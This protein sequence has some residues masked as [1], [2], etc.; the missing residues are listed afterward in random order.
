MRLEKNKIGWFVHDLDYENVSGAEILKLVG[1]D[2]LL[3]VK[4]KKPVEPELL[5]KLYRKLGHV[6]MQNEKVGSALPGYPFICRVNQ[7]TGMFHT[8]GRA[9]RLLGW[10]NAMM[11]TWNGDNV[12][13]MY[14][15]I[16]DCEGGD[17]GFTDQALVWHKLPREVKNQLRDLVAENYLYRPQKTDDEHYGETGFFST[18][19]GNKAEWGSNYKGAAGKVVVRETQLK[20]MKIVTEHPISKRLGLYTP[21]FEN[22]IRKFQGMEQEESTKLLKWIRDFS[23][24]EEFIYWHDWDDYDLVINDQLHGYHCRVPYK[25]ERELWRST[26]CIHDVLDGAPLDYYEKNVA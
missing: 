21:G 2:K 24:Q 25:G 18:L 9:D 13:A 3:I 19:G 11:S 1:N 8:R 17:T 22:V 23:L 14:M 15:H 26:M 16:Q 7:K 20:Q 10:H 12:L 5:G 6:A 4:N